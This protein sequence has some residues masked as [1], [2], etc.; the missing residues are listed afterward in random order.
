MRRPL[1]EGHRRTGAQ[2][3]EESSIHFEIGMD[4]VSLSQEAENRPLSKDSLSASCTISSPVVTPDSLNI[5]NG[6]GGSGINDGY[7][8][9]LNA[10]K[11]LED[12]DEEVA[13][14]RRQA[15]SSSGEASPNKRWHTAASGASNSDRISALY[16][17]LD[18]V[19]NGDSERSSP[20][21]SPKEEHNFSRTTTATGRRRWVE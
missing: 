14:E 13:N 9:V 3:F 16:S 12:E 19:E 20:A 10:L 1:K 7:N 5:S 18:A 21:R 6:K 11:R 2:R 17:Y 8:N 15:L 4:Q